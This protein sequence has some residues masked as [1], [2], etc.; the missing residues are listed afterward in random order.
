MLQQNN[1]EGIMQLC[2]LKFGKKGV[3]NGAEK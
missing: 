1:P 3:K 2:V